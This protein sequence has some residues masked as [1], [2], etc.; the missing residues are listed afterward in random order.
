MRT[1]EDQIE[2]YEQLCRITG[3]FELDGAEH[4]LDCLGMRTWWSAPIE[5]ERYESIRAVASWFF[6][7]DE[8]LGL[9]AFRQRKARSHDGDAV[10]AALISPDGATAVEDP[11]LSTTYEGEGWPVR[12]G[13]ELW[14]PGEEDPEQQY[15]RRASG[16][17]IGPRVQAS[18][19]GFEV[20]AEPFRW[21]SRGRAGAGIYI[22]ARR[23]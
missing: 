17:A 3:R 10:A 6:E 14:L 19:G 11:R 18:A 9:V 23:S 12:A 4:S 2:G 1:S 22:L 21:H 15:P 20:R 7:P 13:L 16:E 8:G 5:L